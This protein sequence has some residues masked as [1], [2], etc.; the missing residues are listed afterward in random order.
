MRPQRRTLAAAS[1]LVVVLAA[2]GTTDPDPAAEEPGGSPPETVEPAPN[3]PAEDPGNGPGEGDDGFVV[4]IDGPA[5]ELRQRDGE[6]VHEWALGDGETFHSFLVHPNGTADTIDVAALALYGERPVL[7]HVYARPGGESGIAEFPG[8]LQPAHE[9]DAGP[10]VFA[11]TPDGR[12]LVWTEPS[13]DAMVL[14]SVGWEDGPGTGRPADD[15]ASFALDAPG[16]AH[17]DGFEVT[18]EA[19]WTL[20]LRGG[21]SNEPIE[22]PIERQGDGG[23][24]LPPGR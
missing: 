10:P 4:T 20:I 9:V 19:A 8:H 17:V 15:N 7:L 14:R 1:L 23:L 5:I 22:I 24:A 21:G 16:G 13:G 6:H 18:A 11:W 2:C 3:P 12:S